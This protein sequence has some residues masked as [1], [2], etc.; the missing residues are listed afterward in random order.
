MQTL[1]LNNTEN[2]VRI[3]SWKATNKKGHKETQK[4]INDHTS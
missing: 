3:K 1:I 2:K 4:H